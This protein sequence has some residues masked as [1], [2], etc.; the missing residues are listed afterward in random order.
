VEED[1]PLKW[2]CDKCG[3]EFDLD[4]FPEEDFICPGC[5]DEECTFILA[6]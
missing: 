2:K 4:D 5:G 1:L 3:H 6:D